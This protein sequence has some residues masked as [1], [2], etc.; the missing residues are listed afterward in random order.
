MTKRKHDDED[1]PVDD[2]DDLEDHDMTAPI[3]DELDDLE[4][5]PPARR[6]RPAVARAGKIA[7]AAHIEDDPDAGDE[8]G[9]GE[10]GEDEADD[11]EDEKA[12][13]APEVS[14]FK[15]LLPLIAG[16]CFVLIAGGSIFL[17]SLMSGNFGEAPRLPA[18][19]LEAGPGV[20]QPRFGEPAPAQPARAA[21]V[22]PARLEPVPAQPQPEP[23]QARLPS[24]PAAEEPAGEAAERG[25]D[26]AIVAKLAGSLRDMRD[27]LQATIR[28]E[29]GRRDQKIAQLGNDVTRIAAV[30][31]ES[32]AKV[33]GLAGQVAEI[34]A[35]LAALEAGRKPGK[36]RPDVVAQAKPVDPY[37]GWSGET[38]IKVQSGLKRLGYYA[39]PVDC[40]IG[41]Q[42]IAAIKAFQGVLGDEASGVLSEGQIEK[43]DQHAR[44]TAP[45]AA[46]KACGAEKARRQA[47]A[48]R[49]DAAA[50]SPATAAAEDRAAGSNKVV[51]GWEIRAV[52]GDSAWVQKAGSGELLEVRTGQELD[53]IGRVTAIGKADGRW[54]IQGE[55]ATIRQNS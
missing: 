53:G 38:R 52:A 24:P 41:G 44:F 11:E 30:Q 39:G 51:G 18:A 32:S 19:A 28:E 26:D 45:V 42:S 20:A 55:L 12:A 7:A 54:Q 40:R 36:G 14:R 13:G 29:M 27:S 46:P 47:T 6:S 50:S 9:L 37:A 31:E 3:E 49:S 22:Q 21:A 4:D 17:P 35:R 43:L 16:G 2:L 25:V 5:G 48:A 33:G 15:K 10:E 23:V 1:I 34:E 8:E